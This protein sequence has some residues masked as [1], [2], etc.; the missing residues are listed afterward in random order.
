MNEKRENG[1]GRKE[2]KWWAGQEDIEL[3]SE[4]RW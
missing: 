3:G 2:L 1:K 4:R